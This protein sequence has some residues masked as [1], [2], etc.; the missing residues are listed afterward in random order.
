VAPYHDSS[1]I[2]YG[3]PHG[4]SNATA[5]IDGGAMDGFIGQAEKGMGC[6]TNNPS[7]SPC[8]Q[9]LTQGAAC[10]DVMGYHDAREI[11]NYWTY[12]E[13]FV[14]QDHM[15]E[16]NASW[17]LPQHLFM[18]SEWSAY[19]ANPYDAF[20]CKGA[21]QSPNADYPAAAGG[22]GA[23]NDG[24]LHYAWTDITW[25]LHAQNV[26]WRYYVLKGTEPDCEVDTSMTCTPVQQRAQTPGIWNPL[27]S[28]TDV[29]EDDQQGNIQ[30]LSNFFTAAKAGTL[31][32]VSWIT[33]NGTVS[34]HPLS[35]RTR[36]LIASARA[37][38]SA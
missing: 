8:Q 37:G 19:C 33:P 36:G 18:V 16:P 24:Q 3:G 9:S 10:E 38:A 1:D 20:S 17:S 32:A 6:T 28:F 2:N 23:Q 21:L 4:A 31:P 11:P 35:I 30:S 13:D 14:L 34:E 29:T 7:C 25:L 15:F 27:P 5:D 22:V 12:A 26:G